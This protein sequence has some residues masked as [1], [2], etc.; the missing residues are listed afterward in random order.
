MK[1]ALHPTLKIFNGF[2]MLKK[3]KRGCLPRHLHRIIVE[4]VYSLWLPQ[5]KYLTNTSLKYKKLLIVIQL[6]LHNFEG[7]KHMTWF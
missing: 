2:S 1:S 4:A 6:F 7:N 3:K 5:M